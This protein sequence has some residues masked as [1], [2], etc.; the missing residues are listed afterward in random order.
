MKAI[1]ALMGGAVAG[2]ISVAIIELIFGI[3][4]PLFVPAAAGV[5]C[6][7]IALNQVQKRA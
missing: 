7:F 6:A 1:L 2:G 3:E 4:F 5:I